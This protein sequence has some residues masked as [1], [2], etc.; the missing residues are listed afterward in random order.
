MSSLFGHTRRERT[1]ADTV[2][3]D[4]LLRAGC[5]DQLAAGIYTYMPLGLRVKHK[6]EAIIR[7]EM[8]AAGGQEV[9]MPAIQP[10][11]LWDISGRPKLFGDSLFR[12]VDRRERTMV[13]APTHE[14]A[15]TRLFRDHAQSYRDVPVTLY[16]VQTK[17]RDEQRPR[18]GLVRVREFTMKDAY[19]FD[20]DDDG[21]DRSYDAMFRA[22]ARIF[23]RCGVPT[24]PV[25][26]DSGAIGGKGSQEFIFVTD[27]GEDTI[28]ICD[29]GDY[30]ANTE[31]A[32]FRRVRAEPEEPLPREEVA[33]P[34]VGTIEALASFLGIPKSGTAKAVLYR[35]TE[36]QGEGS[37][38]VFAVVRGDME[39]N[40][41]KLMNAL[42]GG[43]ELEPL[44]EAEA[45]AIGAVP[46][47]ASPVGLR[48]GTRVV[49]DVAVTTT[50]NLVAGA[51]RDG[52]HLRN[53]NYGRDWTT[54][55]VA[56]IALA[57]AGY[58]CPRCDGTLHL[59]RGIEM[60]HVFR[61]GRIYSEAFEASV[62][63]ESGAQRVPTMGCYGIGVDRIVAAAVEAHH[64]ERGIAW[65]AS[66]A[67][68]DVHLVGLG[69]GRD[70]AL[71]ADAEALYGELTSAG[72]EVLFDDRDESPG[73]KF[74]DADLIGLPIRMTVS[75]RNRT[76]NVVEVKAREAAE[77]ERMPRINVV[78][79][80]VA[81]KRQAVAS[82]VQ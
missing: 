79:R 82:L 74:N 72:L 59:A 67:P 58:G 61:L 17:F 50:P 39:V 35:A 53:V 37:Y 56:D 25:E 2:N 81:M 34:N 36:Q 62:L 57:Q 19:S 63:D 3:T 10:F 22:Y 28:V 12:V 66:I 73:V 49:A 7:Q 23:A 51:N 11:E 6:V 4:L 78:E 69:L 9:L 41:V 52:Y 70:E 27:I 46:G 76:D 55:H 48:E 64:D 18:G 42:G 1:D 13:L 38:P 54:P 21:L 65:P 29:K 16:Q 43:V 45:E 26:A 68:Y 44:S 5:I 75:S 71:A 8:D 30:A 31:K 60:G 32:E 20:V 24:T 14:E 77:A 80:V 47:Y 33:T 40:E 15:V